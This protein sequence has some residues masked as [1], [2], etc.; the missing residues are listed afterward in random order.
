MSCF[1]NL[2]SHPEKF[3]EMHLKNVKDLAIEFLKEIPIDSF[4]LTKEQLAKL[5]EITSLAH[6]IG[7]STEFF[8]QYLLRGEK[9]GDKE[10]R[11]SLLSSIIA[12]YIIKKVFS[13]EQINEYFKRI[14]PILAF[15][16]VKRHHGNIEEILIEVEISKKDEELLRVQ[17]ENIDERKFNILI[18]NLEKPEFQ[19]LSKNKL[20]EIL[21]IIPRELKSSKWFLRRLKAQKSLDYYF[22]TNLLFSLLIDADKSEVAIG[23]LK[24]NPVNIPS[25]V[26]EHYKTNLKSEKLL[27]NKLREKAYQEVVNRKIDLDQKLYFLNLPTGLGK[28][29]I[30]F[31]FAL[32]LREEIKRKKN[33]TPRIVYSLPFLTIIEQNASV[34]ENILKTYFRQIDSSLILKHHYLSET[35][36]RYGEKEFEPDE[37]KILIEGWNSE[38]IITTFVQ[39]FHALISNQNSSLRKLH[40]IFGSIII[41]DEVQSIP[42]KY[43]LLL[44]EIFINLAQKFNCYLIFSTAT[45][46]LILKKEEMTSLIESEDYFT[47]LN[48]TIIK[49]HLYEY[50]NLESFADRLE[51]TKDKSYLFI[52]N[53]INS[54]K[55]FYNLLKERTKREDILFLSSHIIPKE[56]LKRIKKVKNRGAKILVSTQLVEAGVDIDFEVVY[57]DIAPLDSINQSAGRCNRNWE[58]EIGEVYVYS[59]KDEKRKFSSYIYDAILLDVTEKIIRKEEFIEEKRFIEL[60]YEY[61]VELNRRKSLDISRNLLEATYSLRYT[62]YSESENDKNIGISN[63]KLI[64]EDVPKID[65]FIEIDEKAKFMWEKYCQL[66]EIKNLFEK[67]LEFQKIKTDFYQYVIS[68]P[69][70][71]ENLPPIIY[72]FGYVSKDNLKDFYDPVTGYKAK[73]EGIL[74]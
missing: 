19:E 58:K 61:F 34:I 4:P 72:G 44:R 36:Y 10:T 12:Y 30:S 18:R 70:N 21:E 16:T 28:T 47:K 7:K 5:I 9:N 31:A 64:T 60:I 38:I 74:W 45:L 20:L 35:Y 37:A 63:F 43:W 68:I 2:Y 3:L 33:Y 8:Q 73:T 48:R 52:F 13:N 17:V 50:L 1:S 42:F 39:L 11:H 24:R 23:E 55:N 15:L 22:L 46:P 54:A 62:G 27:I 66:K 14:L 26:V 56:R 6:D 69:Q 51:I 32:K 67:R 25:I 59:L 53:T 40:N 29:L 49:P 41:L 57:R 65:V 71:V